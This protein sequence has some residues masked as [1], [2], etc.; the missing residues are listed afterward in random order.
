MSLLAQEHLYRVTV[1]YPVSIF[2]FARIGV[3]ADA[4]FNLRRPQPPVGG[5]SRPF[6]QR[7][8]VVVPVAMQKIFV[9]SG[10]CLHTR[11]LPGGF[12]ALEPKAG[13][14][15]HAY[16]RSR[17]SHKTPV[18]PLPLS[19]FKNTRQLEYRASQPLKSVKQRARKR[20]PR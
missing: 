14:Q 16:S 17:N 1:L 7:P 13:P 10:S 2:H 15:I 18:G 3:L 4:L 20:K 9:Y 12:G 11:K 8:H 19:F 5:R 6:M